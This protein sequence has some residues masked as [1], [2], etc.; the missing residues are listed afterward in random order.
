M[1]FFIFLFFCLIGSA[2]IS[3]P[4]I[5]AEFLKG[6]SSNIDTIPLVVHHSTKS[7]QIWAA[8]IQGLG[9][10]GTLLALNQTWYSQYPRG[11]FKTFNDWKEWKQM[12]KLGHVYG[13]YIQ[14]K[15]SMELW[16]WAGAT[17]NT[18]IWLGGLTGTL[19]QTVVEYMD[20]RSPQWGWS[21]SDVGANLTGSGLLIGQELAW[22]EQRVHLKFSFH[23]V[24]YKDPE[25]QQRSLDL[26][27]DRWTTRMLKD[28]NAQTYWASFRIASFWKDAKVPAWLCLAVG[29]GADGLWGARSNTK[30]DPNGN[31]VFDRREIPRQRTWYLSPDI[32]FTKIPTDKKW[33]KTVFFA[34]NAFKAPLPAI[35][36]QAGK[37]R[38]LP[39]YF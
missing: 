22:N 39:L 2:S 32:D 17:R 19:F 12:D 37:W 3:Q 4:A 33:L 8:A 15:T 28:Y 6:D 26:F 1:R 35:H 25:L 34:L 30:L 16:R 10:G 21:W 31:T 20:G 36:Y 29:T 11:T 38:L 27:G 14:G 7:K 18:Q 24:R 5:S 23:P 13:T 9:Y